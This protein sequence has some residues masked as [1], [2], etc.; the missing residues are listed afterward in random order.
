[1]GKSHVKSLLRHAGHAGQ[2]LMATSL[3]WEVPVHTT[4]QA[5]V[6]SAWVV[7]AVRV[8]TN[9]LARACPN[10][11]L[12]TQARNEHV[13]VHGL[14]LLEL[15]YTVTTRFTTETSRRGY[16]EPGD[17]KSSQ[18]IDIDMHN[19]LLVGGQ[20]PLKIVQASRSCQFRR[21]G[22]RSNDS[23]ATMLPGH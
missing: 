14:G 12:S 1:M 13:H 16:L 19:S 22:K 9:R 21:D 17:M 23:A 11:F 6:N 2:R 10:Q 5:T 3:T 7:L 20:I 4:T 8:E 18:S 15:T